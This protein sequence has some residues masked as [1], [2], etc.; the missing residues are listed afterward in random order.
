MSIKNYKLIDIDKAGA[1]YI[2]FHIMKTLVS[3]K[4]QKN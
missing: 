1:D 4:Y 2:K 3:A